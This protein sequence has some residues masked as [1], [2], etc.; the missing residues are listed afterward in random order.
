MRRNRHDARA[1]IE[2]ARGANYGVAF[3]IIQI[4]VHQNRIEGLV[5]Q[6]AQRRRDA[7]LHF[8]IMRAQKR[9]DGDTRES[10]VV[11]D[12]KNF[13]RP[14]SRVKISQPNAATIAPSKTPTPSAKQ[15]SRNAACSV[16]TM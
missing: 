11:F 7:R 8:D 16:P 12:V 3:A 15:L 6:R 2:R 5:L 1:R 14:K 10:R 13:H 9:S 4:V